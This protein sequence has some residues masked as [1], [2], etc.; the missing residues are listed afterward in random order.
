MNYVK[1][2]H[3]FNIIYSHLIENDKSPQEEIC[4][5]QGTSDH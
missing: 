4:L 5:S 3:V 2:I 1:F